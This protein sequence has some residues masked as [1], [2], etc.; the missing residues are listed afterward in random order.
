MIPRTAI[1][2]FVL[3][4]A[5]WGY[6][7]VVMK[8]ALDYASALDFAVL[9]TL[10]GA[11]CLFAI[12]ALL[13]KSY[14]PPAP[15]RVLLL[16]LLQTTGFL[17]LVTWALEF[18]G[19][20]KTAVLAFT[21]PFWVLGFAALALGERV[22]DWQWL[23]VALAL[24]GLFFLIGPWDPDLRSPG[25]LLAVA[26]GACWG[27]SAVV[28]KTIPVSDRWQLLPVTGWQMVLGAIPLC[29]LA[30]VVERPPIEWSAAFSAALAF[31]ILPANALAWLFWL[32]ILQ[33]LPA[34]VTGLSALAIPVVGST[35][36]WLQ[37]GERPAGA[38]A[39]GMGLILAAL[40][41]LSLRGLW[42]Q[43]RNRSH[44]RE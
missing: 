43:Y 44:P 36:A 38:E 40:A 31:N 39:L 17:G 19:A 3:L 33:R 32:Y 21:M 4:T 27:A 23:A 11:A 14:R 7:W 15:R 9:R 12:I 26:A 13:G 28:S 10:G 37:L 35:A 29:L 24:L 20:S 6:N 25:S 16:G 5:I 2:A 41:V 42:G 34:G 18:E 30:L 22:R 8:I 1:A